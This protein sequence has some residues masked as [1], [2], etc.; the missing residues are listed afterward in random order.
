MPPRHGTSTTGSSTIAVSVPVELMRYCKLPGAGT[1]ML[2][3][4]FSQ[5]GVVVVTGVELAMTFL[6]VSS[7]MS[8]ATLPPLWIDWT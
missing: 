3:E 8:I 1:G 4:I 6:A 7:Q 5:S 2:S